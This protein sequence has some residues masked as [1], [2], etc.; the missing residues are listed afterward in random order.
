MT[1]NAFKE[2]VDKCLEVG[3]NGHIAKTMWNISVRYALSYLTNRIALELKK[4]LGS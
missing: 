4:F 2:D 3:M 1:A